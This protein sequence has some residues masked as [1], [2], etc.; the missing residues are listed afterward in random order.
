MEVN[1][2]VAL[3]TGA[4]KGIGAGIAR[5]MAQKGARL[6][7]VDMDREGLEAAAAGLPGEHA[8]F[9]GSVVDDGFV[10]DTVARTVER[11]G[12]LDILVNNAGII[13]DNFLAKIS[14]ED[15]DAVL[16]VNLKGPFLL[17]RAVFPQ[18]K[19]QRHGKIVNIVSR[20]WL[21][22]IGQGN[23]SASKGGLV[24]LTR[25]LALEF[26][27]YQINVNGVAPGLIDTPMTQ[28]M[29]DKARERLIRMQ[30]TGKMGKV[31]DIAAAVTFLAS[32]QAE[33]IT[34]QILHVDGGKSCGLLSLG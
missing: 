10:K 22:N 24:S 17:C 16:S 25:T 32:D 7:L 18:M 4:A 30:P 14:E 3:I 8:L 23:Y 20:A 13:R 33:F 27:R 34:G 2:K 31:D 11:F 21:G 5:F 12:R 6:A 28:G 9:F 15:W 29:P 26:A 1:G 19:E